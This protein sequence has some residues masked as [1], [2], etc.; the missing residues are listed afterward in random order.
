MSPNER[1][2]L[3]QELAR[4]QMIEASHRI[5]R[6][7]GNKAIVPLLKQTQKEIAKI[8]DKLRQAA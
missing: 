5:D 3:Q 8:Q 2:A 4:L 1:I 7:F 6:R